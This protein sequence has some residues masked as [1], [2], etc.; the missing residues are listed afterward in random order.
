L[1]ALKART[2]QFIDVKKTRPEET[3]GAPNVSRAP[4]FKQYRDTDGLFYFKLVDRDGSELFISNGFDTGRAA[5]QEKY[6]LNNM[7][8][9]EAAALSEEFASTN[10][11]GGYRFEIRDPEGNLMF[12]AGPVVP[13]EEE[14]ISLRERFLQALAS[15]REA[16]D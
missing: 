2:A 5:A 14:S 15:L 12:G 1:G 13:S 11:S 3:F 4:T 16:A 6:H 7:I 8:P 10:V 9:E